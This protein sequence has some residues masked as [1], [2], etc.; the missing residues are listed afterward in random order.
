MEVGIS[1]YSAAIW[2]FESQV[3]VGPLYQ[4]YR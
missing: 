1:G 4:G 3:A 2:M